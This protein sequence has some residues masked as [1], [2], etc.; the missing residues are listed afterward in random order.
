MH[1]AGQP[2]GE[3]GGGL[4]HG[5]HSGLCLGCLRQINDPQATSLLEN[6]GNKG[7]V[8]QSLESKKFLSRESGASNIKES[9]I[10][11]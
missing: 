10:I 4:C 9:C 3:P 7:T 2:S 5:E 6:K 8:S 1:P 11:F